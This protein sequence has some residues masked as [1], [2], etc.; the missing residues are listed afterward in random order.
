MS[1]VVG[2]GWGFFFRLL[3]YC[4]GFL[5]EMRQGDFKGP[6]LEPTHVSRAPL[7][8]PQRVPRSLQL[9][10]RDCSC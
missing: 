1:G 2:V 10:V 8:R 7:V 9:N 3:P 6:S 5:D 4:P